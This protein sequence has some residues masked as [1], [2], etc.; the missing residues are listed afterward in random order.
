MMNPFARMQGPG[1]IDI[2]LRLA[3]R[4]IVGLVGPNGAGKTTLLRML[5]GLLPLEGGEVKIEG[6]DVGLVSRPGW[7]KQIVGFMPEEVHWY[8]SHS[9]RDVIDRLQMMRGGGSGKTNPLLEKVGLHSRADD[10][11]DSLS[12]GMRQ[13]L[14]LACALLGEPRIL[15]LDEPMNGLDPVAREAFRGVL[16][17]LAAEGASILISSHE[18]AE[19]DRIVD[20]IVLMHEGR[21]LEQGPLVDIREQLGLR[22]SLR[23]EGTWAEVAI[24]QHFDN[25]DQPQDSVDFEQVGSSWVVNIAAPPSG[26]ETG[27]RETLLGSMVE[28]G[29]VP[30]GFTT[31]RVELV[32]IL[33]AATGLRPEDVGMGISADIGRG[34][35]E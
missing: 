24:R 6:E 7:A 2:D 29:M 13:R 17:Q 18:L 5:A 26:W 33:S 23:V 14:S 34:E 22:G 11:L 28:A 16:Q 20:H 4:T 10:S 3:P 12:Q 1:V 32:D 27:E 31:K 35:E 9:P 25:S 15:L 21:L 30:L 19:L 8:G